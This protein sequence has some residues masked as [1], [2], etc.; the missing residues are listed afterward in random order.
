M[1]KV[2][3]FYKC[4]TIDYLVKTNTNSNLLVRFYY[5]RQCI[6]VFDLACSTL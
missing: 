4:T 2:L 5:L 6:S 3:K 1:G